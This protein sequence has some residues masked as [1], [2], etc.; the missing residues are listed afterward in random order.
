MST[1]VDRSRNMHGRVMSPDLPSHSLAKS[2]VERK[3]R[4]RL[5]VFMNRIHSRSLRVSIRLFA[6]RASS[7]GCVKQSTHPIT[8]IRP[9]WPKAGL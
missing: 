3:L 7:G 2:R 9:M 6:F 1:R 5:R 8:R 4:V